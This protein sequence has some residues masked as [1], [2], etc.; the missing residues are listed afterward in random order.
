[1]KQWLSGRSN[2]IKAGVLLVA[3]FMA[4]GG[5]GLALRP[6]EHSAVVA[7]AGTVKSAH[8]SKLSISEKSKLDDTKT[9]IETAEEEVPFVTTQT[10]DGTLL[11]DTIVVKVEGHAG[12]KV[13][14][15][16][17]KTRDGGEISRALI[18]ETVTVPPV[19][20]VVAI[21]TK[22]GAPKPKIEKTKK[23]ELTAVDCTVDTG[24]VKTCDNDD[25][26]SDDLGCAVNN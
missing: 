13:V 7:N 17:V 11:K 10:Y 12:K 20:K 18:S 23:C 24:D 4:F 1:M 2:K 5:I 14:K 19:T 21:G 3:V 8:T 6:A 25:A 16:E 26:R 15:S 9:T 22:V